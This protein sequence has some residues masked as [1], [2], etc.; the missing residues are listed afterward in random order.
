VQFSPLL[1]V[2]F[3]APSFYSTALTTLLGLLITWIVGEA[4][5]YGPSKPPQ[6]PDDRHFY[7]AWIVGVALVLLTAT[8]DCLRILS[9][10]YA[11]KWEEFLVWSALV[12]GLLSITLAVL[13]AIGGLTGPIGIMIGQRLFPVLAALA[14]GYFASGRVEG[15][16][17]LVYGTCLAGGCGLK[18]REGAGPS[19]PERGR[20]LADGER[21]LI[22]CQT[23]GERVDLGGTPTRKGTRVWDLLDTGRYVSDAFVDTPGHGRFSSVFPK[24]G[25]PPLG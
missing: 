11:S 23:L 10:G 1:P 22:I 16:R 17:Y 18:Q 12:L 2:A 13:R 19:F 20:R 15:A 6:R 14:V 4:R 3:A 7:S 9:R 25:G 8:I 24:C 5:A 21:V